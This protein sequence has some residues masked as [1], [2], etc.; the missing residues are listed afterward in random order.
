M[1]YEEKKKPINNLENPLVSIITPLY[2]AS[3]FILQN[4][5][6][7]Q[8]QTY[9][10]WEHIII[11]DASTD[12]SAVIVKEFTKRDPRIRFIQ[13]EKNHGAAFCRN[14]ATEKAKGTFMAFLDSDDYWHSEKL[15][16]QINFM[17]QQ[18]AWVSFTHYLHVDE[19]GKPLGKR[20]LAL[21][22]LPYKK[23]LLNNYIGNLTGVYNAEKLGKIVAPNIRKRQDWAVWL[24][25]IKRSE[26][27]ALGIQ[28]DLAF[29]RIRKG[30]ISSNK[31]KLIKYNYLFYR[32]LGFNSIKSG[33]YLL[34]F[35]WEYFIVRPKY[36]QKLAVI[37]S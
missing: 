13:L 6:S 24:E 22:K 36:I 35:F 30:S 17:L 37:L 14:L 19:E 31:L 4:L 10:N 5:K 32:S 34:R 1:H 28:E 9:S 29:Y 3:K 33:G 23:Q 8:N 12:A 11:D 2:N 21:P 16:K 26:T 20:I 25:A 27:P 15:Q 18:D 7:V